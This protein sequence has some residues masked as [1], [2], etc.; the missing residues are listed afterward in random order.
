MQ[1]ET[2]SPPPP[3][4][5]SLGSGLL[6]LILTT[7]ALWLLVEAFRV[8]PCWSLPLPVLVVAYP[9]WVALREAFLLK[10]RSLL[11]AT[12]WDDSLA[13]HLLWGGQ[14]GSVLLIFPALGFAALLLAYG[15]RLTAA[16]WTLLF[17]DAVVLALLYH[18]YQRRL[19][20]Q[21]RPEV[22]GVVVRRWPLWSTN[23]LVLSLAF[24][25]LD[26]FLVGAPDWRVMSW[27]QVAAQAFADQRQLVACPGA[28][29][30]VGSLA[31]LEQGSWAL[32][33]R[34]I[35]GLPGVE[36]RVAAWGLFL[37]QLGLLS[38]LVTTLYRGV[39]ALV[40]QRTLRLETLTGSGR[41]SRAFLGTILVLAVLYTLAALRLRD[42]DPEAFTSPA[43]LVLAPL[44]P[45]RDATVQTEEAR[46]T[47]TAQVQSQ[48]QA[49]TAALDQRIV[50]EVDRLFAPVEQRVEAYL[51]WYFTVLGEYQRLGAAVM[52]DLAE[53]M[54]R[55]LE[56]HLFAD[57]DFSAGLAVIEQALAA[58][59]LA[60]MSA[61]SGELKEHLSAQVREKPCVLVALDPQGLE[62]LHRD[63][64]RA[65]GAALTGVAAGTTAAVIGKNLV[66]AVVAKVAAKKSFQTAASLGAKLEVK[67]GGGALASGLL[68]TGACA[69]AGPFA[70]LC[71]VGG[72]LATWLVVDKVAIEI[73]E[74]ISREELRADILHALHEEKQ[75]LIAAL[76]QRQRTLT[77]HLAQ[78]VQATLDGVFIPARDGL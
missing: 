29:W 40:E 34:I 6:G 22:L 24:F 26:F 5:L 67:K 46:T 78:A 58:D 72:A 20:R 31:A 32:A 15:T 51:D 48:Q 59:A 3:Q 10:R 19:A 12:T 18:L 55:K 74:R 56:A 35:P 25:L 8:L 43:P 70:L 63:Q 65:G 53:L 69:P 71:G 13:R 14:I 57:K 75:R 44:D 23:L 39:L 1:R 28:G 45:C 47:L 77:G 33:Q 62:R 2:V 21:V 37:L 7:L 60:Q 36:W 49:V 16:E 42:F 41:A 50:R 4:P 17:A 64:W 52:G 54:K 27:D 68:A 38:Y 9:L 61:L 30:L 66:G 73:D 76:Q 11:A